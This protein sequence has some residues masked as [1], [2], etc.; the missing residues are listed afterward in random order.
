MLDRAAPF[1]FVG[2]ENVGHGPSIRPQV[3]DQRPPGA[4]VAF[5]DQNRRRGK[6]LRAPS[7]WLQIRVRY[8]S[9]PAGQ[10]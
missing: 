4:C 7:S 1:G 8:E 9:F 5:L 10:G 3:K 2:K 6:A